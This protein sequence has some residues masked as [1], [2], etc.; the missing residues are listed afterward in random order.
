M[1]L[2][3]STGLLS[4]PGSISL[5]GANITEVDEQTM[6][7]VLTDS[8]RAAAQA[9]SGL[10]GGDGSTI[11][12]DIYS[13]A[14]RDMAGVANVGTT[15][16]NITVHEVPD[17]TPP[18]VTRGVI[19]YSTGVLE[20]YATET[21]DSTPS[22]LVEPAHIYLDSIQLIGASVFA[23]DTDYIRISLTEA[24]RVAAIKNSAQPG[25]DGTPVSLNV[26]E[27]AMLDI[28]LN[29]NANFTALPVQE[30]AD[31]VKPVV[32]SSAINYGTVCARI[33]HVL[34]GIP[35]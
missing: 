16:M 32:V 2:V 18:N 9:L 4:G 20:V 5:N 23:N 14:I 22:S 17:T 13:G 28:G 31:A 24:Q 21:I 1:Y 6:Y 30:T 8:Q 26:L 33:L 11:I 15:S 7:L 35:F 19:D 27:G 12:L 25:G 3:D 34:I 29:P 10:P